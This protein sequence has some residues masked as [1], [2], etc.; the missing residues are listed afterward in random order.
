M[1]GKTLRR[2]RDRGI[3]NGP[4][5][6]TSVWATVSRINLELRMVANHKNDIVALPALPE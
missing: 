3:G 5:H 4:L 2:S 1:D 6:L